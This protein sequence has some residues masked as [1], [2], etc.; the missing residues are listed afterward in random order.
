MTGSRTSPNVSLLILLIVLC[1]IPTHQ[2]HPLDPLTPSELDQVRT[3]VTT[4]RPNSS[5]HYVG[6]DD[7]DK[8]T[9]L[10]WTPN[11]SSPPRRAFVITR[12]SHKTHEIV[13][14][15]TSNSI[16]SDRINDGQHGYPLLTFDELT[17]ASNLVLKY[18]PFKEA[19]RRRHVRMEEVR[20]GSFTVGW[21]GQK[22]TV[23]T[24]RRVVKVMCSCLG[25]TVN[26]YMRP[27]EGVMVTVDIDE[28]AIVEFRD[29]LL[30]EIPKADGTDYRE[31]KQ[32]PPF[33][34][35]L[36]PISVD[37]PE[38]PSFTIDGHS[39]KYVFGF[40]FELF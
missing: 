13:V 18:P 9:L 30:V 16:V 28:M 25:G 20:C 8:H 12:N 1:F 2:L 40:S 24:N 31:S 15:L 36:K 6:L 27:I 4:S 29:S 10:S 34:P 11:Q 39:V 33:G 23:L 19:M 7:P 14:D 32:K 35:R 26:F 21:F 17:A 5:F 22:R 37:Q 3:I 38:G